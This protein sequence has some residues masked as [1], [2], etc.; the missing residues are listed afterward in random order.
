[1]LLTH[2][3]PPTWERA[4]TDRVEPIV[5]TL[6]AHARAIIPPTQGDSG[7]EVEF[8][9]FSNFGY[10]HW[11]IEPDSPHGPDSALNGICGDQILAGQFEQP[12]IITYRATIRLCNGALTQFESD[13]GTFNCPNG[14]GPAFSRIW[15][16]AVQKL[17]SHDNHG[18]YRP[19][20]VE[21]DE[22]LDKQ[23]KVGGERRTAKP[24]RE[25]MVA[26]WS[27]R[28]SARWSIPMQ[29]SG[30]CRSY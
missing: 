4:Y 17:L 2:A 29:R 10:V 6:P 21:Y 12:Q 3:P 5:S 28:F 16:I 11:H 23:K 13:R 7:G 9:S 30:P 24:A 20:G 1:M 15:Y 26:N 14:L 22:V 25:K 18:A 19:R 27:I 8:R